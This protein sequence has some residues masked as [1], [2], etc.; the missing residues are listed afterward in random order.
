MFPNFRLAQKAAVL[1][2]FWA[3]LALPALAT[4][5]VTKTVDLA[6]GKF[7]PGG[8]AGS[9]TMSPA[10]VRSA[11]GVI[12][13][14]QGVGA[15]GSRAEFTVSSGPVNTSCTIALPAD[16]AV[17]LAGDGRTMVLNSFT[18]LPSGSI[19]LNSAGAGT[20][21]VG[22]TLSVGGIQVA[23]PYAGNFSVVVTCP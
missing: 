21:Y 11:S 5:T 16:G 2:A 9:V 23:G 22:G 3:V 15:S 4:V 8:M 12:L 17:A 14:T 10:G 13:F 20:I 19:T 6:F 1:V 18:S 7:V